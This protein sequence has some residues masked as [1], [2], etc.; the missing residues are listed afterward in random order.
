M[1][2]PKRITKRWLKS[3]YACEDSVKDFNRI[4]PNGMDLT[5]KNLMKAV[6][7]GRNLVDLVD[8]TMNMRWLALQLFGEKKM[9]VI[10]DQA[11]CLCTAYLFERA[12][13]YKVAKL[14]ADELKLK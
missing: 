4:F 11:V 6:R 3:K 5:R 9:W 12:F 8:F 13:H 7:C 1:H 10:T 2:I 14:I